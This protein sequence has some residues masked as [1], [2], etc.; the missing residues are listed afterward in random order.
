MDA[1]AQEKRLS[2]EKP[3]STSQTDQEE[4]EV[5]EDSHSSSHQNQGLNDGESLWKSNNDAAVKQRDEEFDD[6][7]AD[8]LL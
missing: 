7:L 2:I 6:Y 5:E 4:D 8:L 1:P 3:S